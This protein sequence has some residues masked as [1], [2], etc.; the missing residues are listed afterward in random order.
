MK[1][2]INLFYSKIDFT[3]KNTVIIVYTVYSYNYS[4]SYLKYI[5]F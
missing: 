5:N 2:E 3:R 4:S 1:G